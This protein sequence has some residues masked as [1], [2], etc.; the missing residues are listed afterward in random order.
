MSITVITGVPGTG[1]TASA[2]AM[3]MEL[4][5]KRPIFSMGIRDLKIPHQMVPPVAEW[6]ELRP[7]PEDPTISMPFFTF[8]PNSVVFI[9]ECQT[10]Y[11]PRPNGS[12]VP[13]FVAAN[14]TH[15]HTGVDFVLMTQHPSLIDAHVRKFVAR[16]IHIRQTPM[17]RYK[18]EWTELGDVDSK[19]SRELSR[20]DRFTPPKKVFSLYKSAELHTKI[21]IRWPWY[22]YVFIFAVLLLAGSAYYASRRII[23]HQKPQ[24]LSILG[25]P[26]GA[27]SSEFEGGRVAGGK[28]VNVSPAAYLASYVP[29][30]PGQVHTAPVYDGVTTPT[31]AP[32]PAVCYIIKSGVDEQ[33]RCRTQQGTQYLTTDIQCRTIVHQGFFKEWEN[34]D[35]SSPVVAT[36]DP[37][38]KLSA[39]EQP[40]E[41]VRFP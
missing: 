2:V 39:V 20:K 17:G 15:R 14:E 7:L 5:G 26:P 1:K 22:I 30:V 21:K 41:G 11:R 18:H 16:H 29:R 38:R 9:D 37:E 6:T 8:P 35:Q 32:F 3:M 13:D 12:K 4:D 19:V 27:S 28:V 10:I 23:A 31:V 25:R 34:R 24:D 33:C 36:P 40:R